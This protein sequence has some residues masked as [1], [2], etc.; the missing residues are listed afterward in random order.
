MVSN[1]DNIKQLSEVGL[2]F[3]KEVV[4][5]ETTVNQQARILKPLK[6]PRREG[7]NMIVELDVHDY[8]DGV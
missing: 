8:K 4:T 2:Q 6:A 3:F 5:R 7:G 1:I